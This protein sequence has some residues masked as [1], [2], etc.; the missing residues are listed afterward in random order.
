MRCRAERT[1]ITSMRPPSSL[2]PALVLVSLVTSGSAL[3]LPAF[4]GAEGPGAAATGGRGGRVIKVTTLAA[5]GAGSLQEA[6]N[7]TG[8]RIIVFTVSGV[9]RGNLSFGHGNVTVA[10]QTA[11]GGGITIE[12]QVTSDTDEGNLILRHVRVRPPARPGSIAGNQYDSFQLYQ[13]S[14]I[15]LDHCTI[16]W[17]VD[18]TID[19]YESNDVT[20]QWSTIEEPA[21]DSGHPDGPTHNYGL[22]QGPDGHRIAVHHNLFAHSRSRNPAIANGP[23]DV[24]NNVIYNVRQ[25]FVHHNP[26]SGPFN[27]VGN[28]YKQGPDDTLIPFYFDDEN[29]SPVASLKYWL[30]DNFIDDPGDNC[31]RSV[32]NP[33]TDRC[34]PSFQDMNAPVSLR[35]TTPFDF[36]ATVPGW[37]GVTTQPSK[38]AH[39]LVLARAG[40]FPRDA[41]TTRIV[42]EVKNRTGRFGLQ[43]GDRPADL[44]AGLSPGA[45]PADGDNDGMPDAWESSH[46]LNPANDDSSTVRPSGYTAIE[47]YINE[48]ADQMSG[49]AP[50]GSNNPQTGD[51]GSA[52][53]GP[54][55]SGEPGSNNPPGSRTNVSDSGCS[56]GG[57]STTA[58]PAALTLAIAALAR[59]LTRRRSSR[60]R[61]AADAELLSPPDGRR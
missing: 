39:D 41:V 23:A 54:I 61:P 44:M 48:L 2:A 15:I 32:D 56:V 13:F 18:E 50:P 51:G 9:I 57:L 45:A 33:W 59:R 16:S 55:G 17:G 24:R 28:Y 36:V 53:G 60:A 8:A 49:G 19:F 37:V 22:I 47:E 34:H 35:A 6:L 46:G 10:G 1:K 14:R 31:V 30:A 20:V 3:A 11:P 52:G 5:T 38:E 4:P 40:A 29:G 25:G 27:F 42:D 43:A 58:M 12:G 26:A 21:I 7:A